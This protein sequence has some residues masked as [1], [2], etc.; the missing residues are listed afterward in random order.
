[1]DN[2]STAM[3]TL[4]AIIFHGLAVRQIPLITVSEYDFDHYMKNTHRVKDF[5]FAGESIKMWKP[6]I[7]YFEKNYG[8]TEAQAIMKNFYMRFPEGRKFM[9]LTQVPDNAGYWMCKQ[10]PRTSSSMEW[11]K[12]ECHLAPTLEESV[13]LFLDS[14]K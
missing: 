13:K 2:K 5:L 11:K 6:E 4:E 14:K 7:D 12:A 8:P 1:M 3:N 10:Y 9:V